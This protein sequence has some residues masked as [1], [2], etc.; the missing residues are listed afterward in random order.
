MDHIGGEEYTNT[1]GNIW[2]MERLNKDNK[3]TRTIITFTS[4]TT[5]QVERFEDREIQTSFS[6]IITKQ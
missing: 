1:S 5:A 2:R 3:T 4:A 6:Y